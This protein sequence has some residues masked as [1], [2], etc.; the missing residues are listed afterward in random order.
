MSQNVDT[1]L[2]QLKLDNSDFE[3]NAKKTQDT[4]KNLEKD[5]ELKNASKGFD[6]ITK[7]SNKVDLSGT[8]SQISNAI[9][10][11]FGLEKD[12]TGSI[13]SIT[14]AADKVDMSAIALAAD[15]VAGDISQFGM[16][17]TGDIASLTTAAEK[18][19]M[20][21]ISVAVDQITAKFSMLEVAAITAVQ[22][23]TNKFV[24]G[25]SQWV[26]NMAFGDIQNGWNAYAEKTKSIQTMMSATQQ[27]FQ[28]MVDQGFEGTQLEWV[29]SQ[30]ETLAWYT[31][32][33]SY[34]FLDMANNIGKFTSQGINLEDAT[35]QMIGIANW[36]AMAGANAQEVSRAMYNISQA[37]GT[38]SMKLIDWKSIEN[39]NMA[40][41]A[42]KEQVMETAVAQGTLERVS[43][44][45]YHVIGANEDA[46][47]SAKNFNEQL[48]TGWFSSSV[49][50][51]TFDNFGKFSTELYQVSNM[52]ENAEQAQSASDIMGWIDD[53]KNNNK[54][55]LDEL[56]LTD[57]QV[58]TLTE[59][60]ELLA[61][62]EFNLSRES[63]RMGQ[64][65]K[66]FGE[67][68]ESVHEAAKTAWGSVFQ[69]IFGDYNQ[70]KDLWTVLAEDLWDVFVLPVKNIA[71]ALREWNKS[72]EYSRLAESVKN[73]LDVISEAIGRFQEGFF[74]AF[75]IGGA[76]DKLSDKLKEW[77]TRIADLLEPMELTEAKGNKIAAIGRGIGKVIKTIFQI[78]GKIT[79]TV[80]KPVSTLAGWIFR[81]AD[82]LIVVRDETEDTGNRLGGMFDK[83]LS[84][85]GVV[86]DIVNDVIQNIFYAWKLHA[87]KS[88]AIAA[89]LLAPFKALA[90]AFVKIYGIIT[91]KDMTEA[92]SAINRF[93][94]RAR[95]I[96]GTAFKWISE[97]VTKIVD[98]LKTVPGKVSAA[99]QSMN[100]AM[101]E[102][103][104]W[105]FI[106]VFESISAAVSN[107]W[108]KVKN[109][110]KGLGKDK[111]LEDGEERVSIFTKI[112][113]KLLEVLTK[114]WE[115]LKKV[116]N[117]LLDVYNKVDDF[118]EKTTGKDIRGHFEAFKQ[119]VIDTWEKI[120]EVFSKFAKS[121][122]VDDATE[123]VGFFATVWEALK[124]AAGAVVG[125]VQTALPV[126]QAVFQAMW[127][128]I[129]PILQ[130]IKEGIGSVDWASVAKGGGLAAIG[131]ALLKI[132]KGGKDTAKDVK[133]EAADLVS[134]VKEM[135]GSL[136]DTL[137]SFQMELKADAIL[138][139]AGA[140]ILMAVAML[141][142]ASLDKE[143]FDNGIIGIA[144]LMTELA[145]FFIV[146]SKFGGSTSKINGI[147]AAT[148]IMSVALILLTRSI[149]KL[150]ELSWD[151]L[152]IGLTGLAA[153]I[154]MFALFAKFANAKDAGDLVLTSVAMLI[155]A[156]ALKKLIAP[157]AILGA[158][159]YDQLMQGMKAVG[160][161]MLAIA[162]FLVIANSKTVDP[163][164]TA[165][166]G[167]LAVALLILIPAISKFGE[168]KP[169]VLKQGIAVVA[170]MMA[171]IAT[172]LFLA[173]QKSVSLGTAVAIIAVA[174]SILIF[175]KS[176]D[177]FGQMNPEI[178]KK[179]LITVGLL[180]LI[181]GIFAALA[182]MNG[183]VGASLSVLAAAA[184]LLIIGK[185]LEIIVPVFAS[186]DKVS[187]ESIGKGF[188]IF[189]GALLV[190]A[191]A[192]GLLTPVIPVMIGLAA[193]LS[194]IVG[195]IAL[196]GIG[197]YAFAKGLE[198]IANLGDK[199][200]TV[201]SNLIALFEEKLP[202]I[203]TAL[204]NAVIT[205]FKTV[206]SNV[207]TV[208]KELLPM[209]DEVIKPLITSL[210]NIVSHLIQEL[211]NDPNLWASL[212]TIIDYIIDI[213]D[214]EMPKLMQIFDSFFSGLL[215]TLKKNWPKIKYLLKEGF[216]LLIELIDEYGPKLNDLL[217]KLIDDLNAK[218]YDKI[219]DIVNDLVDII[220]KAVS[221]LTSRLPDITVTIF[222]FVLTALNALVTEMENNEPTLAAILQRL[223]KVATDFIFDFIIGVNTS[224]A[225]AINEN[226]DEIVQSFYDLC[227][228]ILKA[229]LKFFGIDTDGISSVFKD[230]GG[231]IIQGLIKG[232]KDWVSNIWNSCKETFEKFTEGVRKFFGME[233]DTEK[234]SEYFE[235][236][237]HDIMESFI[238]AILSAGGN[239]WALIKGVFEGMWDGI[240][241]YFGMVDE[242]GE[243][244]KFTTLA[245]ALIDAFCEG[246]TSMAKDIWEKIKAPFVAAWDAVCE[247]FDY[248]SPSGLFE[249]LGDGII[250]GMIDGIADWASTIWGKIKSPFENVYNSVRGFFGLDKPVSEMQK[251]GDNTMA[252]F[253]NGVNG[254]GGQG[255]IW[256]R[257]SG[258]FSSFVS[259]VRAYLETHS[260]SLLFEEIGE[261]V[262]QGFINGINNLSPEIDSTAT[263]V[264]GGAVNSIQDALAKATESM[265][266][267][268]TNPVITPVLD[269]SEIQNGTG[270]LANM[271]DM[272][273]GTVSTGMN[274]SM[275]GASS[276]S[277]LG[278]LSGSSLLSGSS[279]GGTIVN[280]PINFTIN[281]AE[282]QDVNAIASAV[283]RMLTKNINQQ[284]YAFR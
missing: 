79:S 279:T 64:E 240:C 273:N 15:N 177:A 134:N 139:I 207:G 98:F 59:S 112:W 49:M 199:A 5:L 260:P 276:S 159:P 99:W 68:I 47:V 122:D 116:G 105:N 22:N 263:S 221:T 101:K 40:T 167:A 11:F 283:E 39:A 173:N 243:P 74:E 176:I 202:G 3:K 132:F 89:T 157:L 179:G 124:T 108:E 223:T 17:A 212:K 29:E 13:N 226:I 140:I 69:Q 23:I 50:Q 82:A 121:K 125:W 45:I 133:E 280:Q 218:L 141:M 106:E 175:Q 174:A 214:A 275:L 54:K 113:Q 126:V 44:G 90:G 278:S 12:A 272:G 262:D 238:N 164:T 208:L 225:E 93:F 242:N 155:L 259:N 103:I 236:L 65:A 87:D 237:G 162:G 117:A 120:K 228:A 153:V 10:K 264:F 258:A 150:A 110:F 128:K 204:G 100:D 239:I 213:I 30:M 75:G 104:G 217:F 192:A 35:N 281:A 268:I 138:R 136:K 205:F 251:I 248:H 135:F 78:V 172:F 31:D 274:L 109:F 129:Q 88:D 102:K 209:V 256:S 152:Y 80:L 60:L 63:F 188:V 46:I 111:S 234:N 83:F 161:M 269:L 81:I 27:D 183:G 97:K 178:L 244:I 189:G 73:A 224:L 166:L 72:D 2:V 14:S 185:A 165:G 26:K 147:A 48:S 4:I 206:L 211:A 21:P 123:K 284:G 182:G 261:N 181:M 127:E 18:V 7:A 119:S 266:S 41:K 246:I 92:Q 219:D 115:W 220:N 142:I 277:L 25:A 146:I 254:Y 33:T 222:N 84:V 231:N 52:L 62:E 8:T 114:V 232:V 58:Q 91:G 198:I 197:F 233:G 215:D 70:A 77:S 42:F 267:D 229:V 194:L 180:V 187:W 257:V 230:T 241:K 53:Y 32:E 158:L 191:L 265:S 51:E 9:K 282:G 148:M 38:G 55:F 151:Q 190:L 66:T 37:M 118:L 184:A 20:S 171:I 235:N 28:K 201:L 196:A 67:A 210:V 156:T 186:L 16:S 137:K 85:I 203:M 143:G 270:I 227:D 154:A 130:N 168:M 1:R 19:D 57:A 24:D 95:E 170:G 216:K 160:I 6:N 61:S 144:A 94:L 149:A 163:S 253:A 200:M 36:G 76:G 145:T 193:A 169:D 250:Q 56:D 96:I 271:L 86:L 245:K 255:G 195:S 249:G 252:G 107:A 43:D 131:I 34:N 71:G 247:F